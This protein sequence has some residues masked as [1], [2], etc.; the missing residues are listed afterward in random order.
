MLQTIFLTGLFIG[1]GFLISAMFVARIN[2]R[3]DISSYSRQ[4]R[5]FDVTAH[6]DQYVMAKAIY[7]VRLLGIVGLVFLLVA[8]AALVCKASQDFASL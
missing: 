8:V 6:L 1:L 4:T 7:R 3:P 2:W 5:L